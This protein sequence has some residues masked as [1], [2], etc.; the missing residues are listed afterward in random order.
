MDKNYF[1]KA[2]EFDANS[3]LYDDGGDK[4][5]GITLQFSP[6]KAVF[7][8][9]FPIAAEFN[10]DSWVIYDPE[11]LM[12]HDLLGDENGAY[13]EDFVAA[14]NIGLRYVI[15]DGEGLTGMNNVSLVLN[16]R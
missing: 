7:L 13:V 10:P 5:Q 4:I 1:P 8:V 15:T 3:S 9:S 14:D 6:K 2:E 11:D 12:D 16:V